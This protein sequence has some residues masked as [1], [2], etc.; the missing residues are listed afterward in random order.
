MPFSDRDVLA[1]SSINGV[2]PTA[3]SK[4]LSSGCQSV[5]DY[6]SMPPRISEALQDKIRRL[7]IYEFADEQIDRAESCGSTLVTKASGKYPILLSGI[8]DA[9]PVLFVKGDISV[10][11][12]PSIGVIG[13]REP[14]AHGAITTERLTAYFA[15]L[16]YA[17]VSGLA[18]GCDSIAHKECV[19]LEG[20]GIAV[21]AHG[22]HTIAPK[23]NA[24]LAKSLLESGG[25]LISEFAFGVD[26]QPR[27]FVQRDKTQA[28]LS[29]AVVMVQ[30]DLKGGSLHASRAAIRYGRALVVPFPT[31]TDITAQE[32]KIQANLLLASE[33]AAD[34]AELLGCDESQLEKIFVVRH[35]DDYEA[36]IEF[37][38]KIGE[39]RGASAGTP[40][41]HSPNLL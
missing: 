24:D 2:G 33:N 22:L 8:A 41:S 40:R 12:L 6:A 5:H 20:K 14:T 25:V 13:T 10:L 35:R 15:K 3:I 39:R 21:L 23:K 7:R 37:V 31:K 16:G 11:A 29:E 19:R 30:S 32:A 9:P 17:I 34:I 4:L 36:M 38:K 26:A 27:L 28:L 1:F 18:L